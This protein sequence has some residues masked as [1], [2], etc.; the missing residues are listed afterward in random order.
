MRKGFDIG[1]E[2]A[3]DLGDR[4]GAWRFIRGFTD[5]WTAPLGA[6]DGWDEADLA[7]AEERLGVSFPAAF[8]EAYLLLGR[9]EDLT[10][11]HAVLLSPARLYLDDEKVL[12]F[13]E[14]N[15]GAAFW[16]MLLSD[17]SPVLT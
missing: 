13:R 2:L 4:S 17:G 8:R 11:N 15:Q 12:V 5:N 14:E 3:A 9:R 7:E 10:S 1:C 6:G 16:G